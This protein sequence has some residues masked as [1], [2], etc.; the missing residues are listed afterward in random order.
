MG[1]IYILCLCP[2]EWVIVVVA[3][4]GHEAEFWSRTW[5]SGRLVFFCMS[6]DFPDERRVTTLL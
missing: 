3:K 4:F 1:P 6:I 5:Y 2:L